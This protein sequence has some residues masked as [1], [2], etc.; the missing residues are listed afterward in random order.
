MLS[1]GHDDGSRVSIWKVFSVHL[2]ALLI[3]FQL[4]SKFMNKTMMELMK[5]ETYHI[6]LLRLSLLINSSSHS[7]G[8]YS[9]IVQHCKR[10]INCFIKYLLQITAVRLH[11]TYGTRKNGARERW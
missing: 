5:L 10:I 9:C 8:F 3:A 11:V 6:F 7:L 2:M 4:K 1:H